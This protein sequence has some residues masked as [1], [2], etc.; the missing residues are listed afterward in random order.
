MKKGFVFSGYMFVVLSYSVCVN[1]PH[2]S[3]ELTLVPSIAFQNKDLSFDQKYSGQGVSGN[4]AKFSTHLPMINM[5]FTAVYKKYYL[6]LKHEKSVTS[7]PAA[8]NETD[9]SQ[10]V[11]PQSN[12]IAIGGSCL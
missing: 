7:T 3:D 8:T 9:R 10:L 11:P 4:E 12:L 2:A 6:T 5:S 1:K